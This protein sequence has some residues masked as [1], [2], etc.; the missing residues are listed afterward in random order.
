M[1]YEIYRNLTTRE[2]SI[3]DASSKIVVG[4]AE[5]VG[6][7][8]ARIIVNEITRQRCIREQKKYVHAWIVGEI[9]ALDGFKSYK[10]R[11]LEKY[12][13]DTSNPVLVDLNSKVMLTYN[14]YKFPFFVTLP[15]FVLANKS[16]PFIM[17]HKDGTVEAYERK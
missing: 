5:R 7:V 16:Y 6:I 13:A 17:V 8:N 15:D 12:S 10:G 1:H 9:S 2:L 3:R 14:P 4:H 11:T